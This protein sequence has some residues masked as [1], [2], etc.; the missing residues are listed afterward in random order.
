MLGWE[1]KVEQSPTQRSTPR[2][3]YRGRSLAVANNRCRDDSLTPL[4]YHHLS[5]ERCPGQ[6]SPHCPRQAP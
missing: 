3:Q 6:V 2:S 4:S 5:R 1:N